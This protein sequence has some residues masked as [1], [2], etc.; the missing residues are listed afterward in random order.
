L[1]IFSLGK[2][3]TVLDDNGNINATGSAQFDSLVLKSDSI[4]FKNTLFTVNASGVFVNGISILPPPSLYAIYSWDRSNGAMLVEGNALT[5]PRLYSV[6]FRGDS[7]NKTAF[8]G[9]SSKSLAPYIDNFSFRGFVRDPSIQ[10]F[11]NSTINRAMI[12]WNT[13]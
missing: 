1:G 5:E 13:F 12:F 11:C 7:K 9:F 6:E 2:G 3:Q 4:R 10:P 8:C